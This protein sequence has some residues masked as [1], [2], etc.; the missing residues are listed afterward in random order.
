MGVQALRFATLVFLGLGFGTACGRVVPAGET[1]TLSM[2]ESV[3]GAQGADETPA[4]AAVRVDPGG[5]LRVLAADLRGGDSVVS[6]I[7]TPS[8]GAGIFAFAGDVDVSG[9]TVQGGSVVF[10]NGP[11]GTLR[12]ATGVKIASS[13]LSVSGGQIRGGAAPPQGTRGNGVV[14]LASR[15]VISGGDIDSVGLSQSRAILL[16]GRI[17]AL[18]LSPIFVFEFFNPLLIDPIAPA[19]GQSS[20]CVELRGGQVAGPIFLTEASLFVVGSRFNLPFG[21]V[22][23]A[24]PTA[25][26]QIQLTGVLEDGS[27][28][29]VAIQR[30]GG[31][32]QLLDSGPPLLQQEILAGQLCPE[33]PLPKP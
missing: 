9:G 6:K 32:L 21:E 16:G 17:G 24:D 1:L 11:Q 18:V 4:Q 14:A 22:L 13:A 25:L 7:T 12:G 26:E 2:G 30:Q 8:P 28:I 3:I 5:T 31:T 19:P 10:T 20:S 33:I 23:P 27:A 29:D 15:V